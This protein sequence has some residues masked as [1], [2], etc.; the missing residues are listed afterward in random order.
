MTVIYVSCRS[1]FVEALNAG[2]C[3]VAVR[4]TVGPGKINSVKCSF[5]QRPGATL[6]EKVRTVHLALIDFAWTYN[7]YNIIYIYIFTRVYTV[8]M[9]KYQ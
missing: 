2:R 6:K 3:C 1:H 7:M 4:V 8:N 5:H 9:C